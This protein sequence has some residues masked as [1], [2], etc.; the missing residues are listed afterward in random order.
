FISKS[1]LYFIASFQSVIDTFQEIFFWGNNIFKEG[2]LESV[3]SIFLSLVLFKYLFNLFLSS[4]FKKFDTLFIFTGNLVV[5]IL[6]INMYILFLLEYLSSF[7]YLAADSMI[8][9]S[10]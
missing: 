2:P 7:S 9:I 3:F 10:G 4:L 6:L 5:G 8:I 1:V